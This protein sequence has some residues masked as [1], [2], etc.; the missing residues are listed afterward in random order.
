MIESS[1]QVSQWLRDFAAA[2]FHDFEP[3]HIANLVVAAEMIINLDS[4]VKTLTQKL[5]DLD[6]NQHGELY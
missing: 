4:R 1:N 6:G 3:E 5:N 2:N